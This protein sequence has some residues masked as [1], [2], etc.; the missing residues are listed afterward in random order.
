MLPFQ[1]M[2]IPV[3]VESTT[4]R[5]ELVLTNGGQQEAA[6][7]LTYRES[8]TTSGGTGGTTTVRLAAGE[9]R[10]IPETIDFLRTNGV[11]VGPKG[12]L[13][14]VGALHVGVTG[15]P[16]SRAFA[17]ARTAAR[18]SAAGQFGLFTSP[19]FPG[20]EAATDAWVYGLMAD[21]KSRSNVAVFNTGTGPASAVQLEVTAYD[22]DASGVERGEAWTVTL[23]PGQFAQ[24]NNFLGTRGIRN[25]WVRIRS[26]S[27]TGAWGAY[28][29]VNDLSLIHI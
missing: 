8:I 22:G 7:E 15:I 16:L 5:S 12:S 25:G 9:Q 18:S 29:V 20:D 13:P 11:K 4:Y 27:G 2:T 21:D 28:G 1:Y 6:F 24:Q 23:E 10:I 3:L 14:Y 19:L 17:G 26:M